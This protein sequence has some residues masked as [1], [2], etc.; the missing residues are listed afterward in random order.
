MKI[1]GIDQSLAKTAM[2]RLVGNE[3][4]SNSLSKTGKSSV[5]TI[6][7]DTT[8][9]DTLQEQVHHICSS[10][11]KEVEDFQPD[12]IVF[13]ALSF[14]S[15]G[16]ATRDLA[17]L[18]GAIREVLLADS[19]YASIPVEEI[20]PTSLKAFARDLLKP[21]D[22]VERDEAGDVVMLKSKKPKKVKMDKKVMVKAV[23]EVYGQDYLSGYNFSSGLDDLADSTLL[24]LCVKDTYESSKET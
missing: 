7:K 14:G 12:L 10:I 19:R 1:L 4:V 23:R 6:R 18:Y 17:C 11:L 15:V 5:K 2:T 21:Y 16:N 9:Y 22:Q 24:A 3:G 13:E 20:A 8:Y